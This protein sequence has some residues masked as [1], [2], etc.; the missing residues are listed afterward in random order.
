MNKLK[1]IINNIWMFTPLFWIR[2]FSKFDQSKNDISDFSNKKLIYIPVKNYYAIETK[3]KFGIF[4]DNLP[5]FISVTIISIWFIIY[6]PFWFPIALII[7]ILQFISIV[8]YIIFKFFTTK[9]KNF[10]F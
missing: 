2:S 5:T 10:N 1:Y 7:Y 6:T 4:L 3:T 8:L 9:W